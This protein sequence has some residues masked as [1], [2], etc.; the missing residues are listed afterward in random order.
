MDF[1]PLALGLLIYVQLDVRPLLPITLPESIDTPFYR[2]MIAG[3][4]LAVAAYGGFRLVFA[5]GEALV[6]MLL[7]LVTKIIR[8]RD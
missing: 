3:I 1:I 5:V 6:Y 4:A 2:T 7:R 8:D